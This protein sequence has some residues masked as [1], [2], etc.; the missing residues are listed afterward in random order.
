VSLARG[1]NAG[2]IAYPQEPYG[3]EVDAPIVVERG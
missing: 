3:Q 2:V 1:G